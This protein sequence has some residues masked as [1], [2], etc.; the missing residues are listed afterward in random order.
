M[1][2]LTDVK[3]ALRISHSA[4]DAVIE[5]DISAAQSE[6]I[7]VGIDSTKATSATDPLILMAVKTYVLAAETEDQ[8]D[9]EKYREAFSVQ[10]NNLRKSGAYVQQPDQPDSED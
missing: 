10:V 4:L 6:M 9:A 8:T 3:A 5:A 1:S 2:L 7:R